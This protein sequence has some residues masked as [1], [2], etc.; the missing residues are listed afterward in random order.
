MGVDKS[1]IRTVLHRDCPPSVEAYLQESGR[2]GRDGLESRAV[3]LRGPEDGS[4]LKRLKGPEERRRMMRLL[5]YA[6]DTG[7]CRRTALQKLLDYRAPGPLPET[8]GGACCDVCGAAAD[9]DYREEKSLLDFFRRNKRCH[10]LKEAAAVLAS[11][12]QVRWSGEEAELTLKIL[13]REGK[14]REMT[15]FLWKRKLTL[16]VGIKK[17]PGD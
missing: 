6:G 1:D 4:A 3:L 7:Q 5:D 17:L 11:S 2:A 10:T 14:L 9:S 15:G 13:I 12:E 16:G 8:T